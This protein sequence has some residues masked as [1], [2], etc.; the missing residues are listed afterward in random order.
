MNRGSLEKMSL[1]EADNKQLHKYTKV[2]SDRVNQLEC[3]SRRSNLIFFN[4]EEDEQPLSPKVRSI[5]SKMVGPNTD[6]MTFQAVHRLGKPNKSR[7]RPIIIRFAYLP[8]IQ[9]VWD[10]RRNL[11]ATNYSLDEDIPEDY[12]RDRGL[13]PVMKE[14]MS[15]WLYTN[16]YKTH[17]NCN[18]LGSV[19]GANITQQ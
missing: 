3:Y 5:V 11:K 13:L 10:A 2:L 6:K 19:S 4:I 7:P 12:K 16:N 17:K 9:V 15:K 1:P 14:Y 18:E 8:D